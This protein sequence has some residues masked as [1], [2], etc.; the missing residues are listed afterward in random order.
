[1]ICA[2]LGEIGPV[3][4]EKISK[5]SQCIFSI[6]YLSPLEK[7]VVLHWNKFEFPLPKDANCVKFAWNLP[8]GFKFYL[9]LE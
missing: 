8:S 7:G 3:V 4:L 2:N 9:T 5:Y 1:M 6:S